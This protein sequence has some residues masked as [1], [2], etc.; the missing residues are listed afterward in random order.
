MEP[1]LLENCKE[2][3]IPGTD[4]II[5]GFSQ[6]GNKTGFAI[7]SLKLL[8]DAGLPTRKTPEKLLITH[9]HTDHTFNVPCIAMGHK[10]QCPVYCPSEMK[11]PLL[12]MAR[13][14]QSLNDCVNLIQEEQL[15]CHGVNVGDVIK[16][17]NITINVIKC[18]HTVP[19]VGFELVKTKKRLKDE[20]K[21]L[22][23]KEI[24]ALKDNGTEVTFTQEQKF[25]TFLGDTTVE[26]FNNKKTLE[27]SVLMLECTVL[28]DEIS[29]EE[30][31][32][33]GHM[34][35]K[36]LEPVV[37]ANPSVLFVLIHLS[38]RYKRP[39]IDDFFKNKPKN[40]HVW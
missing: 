15:I 18:F 19:C 9:S 1:H 39:Y 37:I 36:H 6:A 23:G 29:P 16:H 28:N 40:I 10:Q 26:V 25:F 8:F 17:R 24:K 14:S 20:Y 38:R 4:L 11:E 34:H 3:K 12:L 31:K 22:K 2:W 21:S 5:Q 33:R 32:S 27:T 35:W 7:F 30:T 13:A